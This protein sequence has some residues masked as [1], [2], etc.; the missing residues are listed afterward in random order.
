VWTLLL[1][2]TAGIAS[3]LVSEWVNKHSKSENRATVL[4]LSAMS[5]CLSVSLS[6]PL[7]GLYVDSHSTQATY[8]LLAAVLGAYALRQLAMMLLGRRR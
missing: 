2:L 5:G 7:F 4:S 8:L 1:D 3:P 6:A